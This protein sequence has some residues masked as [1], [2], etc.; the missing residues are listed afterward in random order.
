MVHME[1]GYLNGILR[2]FWYA[3]G[4]PVLI[5]LVYGHEHEAT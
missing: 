1:R 4:A 3:R 5:G 2:L